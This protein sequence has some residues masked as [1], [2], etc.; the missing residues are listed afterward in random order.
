VYI[1]NTDGNIYAFSAK[2]GS[3]A[4]RTATGGYVYSSAAVAQVPG[5]KPTVYVGSYDGT[6]YALDAQTGSKRWTYAE[7]GKISGAPTVIG[8]IVYYSNLGLKRTTGLDAITGK[9]IF[10]RHEGAYNAAVSDGKTIYMVGY[11]TVGAYKPKS[12]LRAAAKA[13]RSKAR[14]ANRALGF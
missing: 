3:L 10:S 13:R 12:E 9:K 11:V 7:G 8:D 4:W 1:G 2:D 14:R 5:G 6:L